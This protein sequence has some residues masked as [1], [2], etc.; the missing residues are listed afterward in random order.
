M[1]A[2]YLAVGIIAGILSIAAS[3]FAIVSHIKRKDSK[4][5]PSADAPDITRRVQQ[6]VHVAPT[7][8]PSHLSVTARS[9]PSAM[10]SLLWMVVLVVVSCCVYYIWTNYGEL[11][12]QYEDRQWKIPHFLAAHDFHLRKEPSDSSS[13]TCL[14]RKNEEVAVFEYRNAWVC[15]RTG[16]TERSSFRFP[17]SKGKAEE[18]MIPVFGW[19]ERSAL[20]ANP[21]SS[22]VVHVRKR[23]GE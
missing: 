8:T 20:T 12:P 14:I 15:V 18:I 4:R 21:T 2:I 19:C 23:K 16:H 22:E 1:E 5:L 11:F 10:K 3:Y 17:N 6:I 13:T 7:P 9:R